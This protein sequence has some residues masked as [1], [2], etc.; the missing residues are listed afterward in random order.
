MEAEISP[1]KKAGIT[2]IKVTAAVLAIVLGVS[3]VVPAVFAKTGKFQV[4]S[5]SAPSGKRPHGILTVQQTTKDKTGEPKVVN[6]VFY[7]PKDVAKRFAKIGEGY[8]VKLRFSE[9]KGRKAKPTAADVFARGDVRSM[10]ILSS[11][12]GDSSGKEP[13]GAGESEARAPGGG[14]T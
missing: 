8:I 13:G 12:P 10:R 6:R 2:L 5:W 9:R 4:V 1:K 14:G 3:L 7:V 11:G